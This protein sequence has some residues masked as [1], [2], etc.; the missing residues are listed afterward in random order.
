MRK[1]QI[2]RIKRIKIGDMINEKFEGLNV[3]SK[4]GICGLPIRVDSYKTC[5]FG[6]RYCFANGRKIM[7][8]EKTLLVADVASIERRLDRVFGRGDVQPDNFLDRLIQ[9]RITWHFGG[10]SDPFQPCNAVHRITNQIVDVANKYDVTMLFSTKS[11]TLHDA[12]VRPD[13]HAFQ[14]SVSNVDNI[15]DIE[16]GVPPIENRLRLFKELKRGGYKVGIRIQPFIPNVS[17]L[18]IVKM[19]DGADHFIIEGLKVIPQDGEQKDYCFG[20]LGQNPKHYV[21]MGLLNMLPEKRIELYEPFVAYFREH[22]ISY[23]ISDNDLRWMGN[24]RCCC[25]DALVKKATG[26][27]T[28]GMLMKYKH[29]RLSDVL[30]ECEEYRTCVAKDLFTSNRTDGCRTVEEFYKMRFGRAASPMSPKYQY[31]PQP[32]LF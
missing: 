28:T 3:S 22:G 15:R 21:Q 6:C 32:K 9:N 12:N 2:K 8:F 20:E 24:N 23:S 30:H 17:T 18:D 4:Y 19:F 14:L 27:D 13:L 10:M 7:E 31:T 25:G 11:D 29:W 1:Q 26:F 5:S 16:P